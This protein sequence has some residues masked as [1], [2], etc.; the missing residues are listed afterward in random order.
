MILSNIK[1]LC[2]ALGISKSGRKADIIERLMTQHRSSAS[3]RVTLRSLMRS[4][5]NNSHAGA[6]GGIGVYARTQQR[7]PQRPVTCICSHAGGGAAVCYSPL[8]PPT[9]PTMLS[10]MLETWCRRCRAYAVGRC[11]TG[12]AWPRKM[13]QARRRQT[14]SAN[15]VSSHRRPEHLVSDAWQVLIGGVLRLPG[16]LSA[17]R[18][19]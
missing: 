8:S 2:S 4:D 17:P 11:S 18:A 5:G 13:N 6:S 9:V 19:A 14:M 7:A 15:G 1:P 10:H 12:A 16:A 3:A